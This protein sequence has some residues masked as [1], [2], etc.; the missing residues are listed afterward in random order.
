MYGDSTTSGPVIGPPGPPHLTDPQATRLRRT[1]PPYPC[2]P[3]SL[4][5]VC[6]SKFFILQVAAVIVLDTLPCATKS[7]LRD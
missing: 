5:A 3:R 2:L 6:P 7:C 4:D 1:S